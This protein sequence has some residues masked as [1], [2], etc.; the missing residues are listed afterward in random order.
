MR[1]KRRAERVVC[2]D[3]DADY[4]RSAGGITEAG[5]FARR[6]RRDDWAGVV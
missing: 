5:Q 3:C 4:T 6:S 2:D 1:A